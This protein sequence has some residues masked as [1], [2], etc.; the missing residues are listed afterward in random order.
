[1]PCR[2]AFFRGLVV[3]KRSI[4]VLHVVCIS[5]MLAHLPCAPI[6]HSNILAHAWG[7]SNSLYTLIEL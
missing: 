1:M 3:L 5:Q 7:K 2:K 4:N 6:F